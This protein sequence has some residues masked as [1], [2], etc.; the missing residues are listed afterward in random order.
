MLGE[1]VQECPYGRR[2]FQVH[3]CVHTGFSCY[4]T[5]HAIT[6]GFLLSDSSWTHLTVIVSAQK[7]RIEKYQ[8]PQT[9]L[10]FGQSMA[11]V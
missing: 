3:E 4:L 10:A 7:T 9:N 11:T 6:S 1:W 5:K 8:Q 2:F